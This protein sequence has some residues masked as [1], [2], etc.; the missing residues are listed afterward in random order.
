MFYYLVIM[1]IAYGG[2]SP[3]MHTVPLAFEDR[4]ECMQAGEMFRARVRD[5]V[6]PFII[7]FE[8]VGVE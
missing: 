8:C 7:T 4:G 3:T 5:E 2:Q 1:L 6:K